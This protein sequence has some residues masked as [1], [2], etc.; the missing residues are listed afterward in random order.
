M[1]GASSPRQEQ[2]ERVGR[3]EVL[4]EIAAGGMATVYLA[5]SVGAAGFARLVAIKQLHSHLQADEEFVAMLLDEARLAARIRHPNV[6]PVVDMEASPSLYLVMEYIEGDKLSGLIKALAKQKQ[7]LPPSVAMRIVHDSLE[8]LHEA[9]ILRDEEG[10]PLQII[11]RDISPQNILVGVDGVTRITDFGIAKAESRATTTRDGQL[12]GKV[13]YMAPEQLSSTAIDQRVD[14]FAMAVTL[15]E[16]LAGKRLFHGESELEA[17]AAVA[18]AT[19]PSLSSAPYSLPREVDA[20]VRRGLERDR[21]RRFLNAR[22]FADALEAAA[23]T[24]GGLASTRQVAEVVNQLAGDK[25]KRERE[26]MRIAAQTSSFGSTVT[27]ISQAHLKTPA[28]LEPAPRADAI[29]SAPPAVAVSGSSSRRTRWIVASAVLAVVASSVITA[30]VMMRWNHARETTPVVRSAS[31]THPEPAIVIAT[32]P[33]PAPVVRAE[34]EIADAGEPPVANSA[35]DAVDAGST[36]TTPATR[37]GRVHGR[38]G[39]QRFDD[40]D[41]IGVN[42]YM[43]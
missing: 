38:N 28:S 14:L 33:V 39:T 9:H 2:P 18:N 1:D 11:H 20:V 10:K 3:Y 4:G 7:A 8:G 27:P 21:D 36:R 29:A 41:F 22:E 19:V 17:M 34:P 23:A 42:P 26:R 15:W 30:M 35:N 43:H 13:G 32:P 31:A 16:S 37:T 6:V 24:V 25:I 40:S 5:R 12:K